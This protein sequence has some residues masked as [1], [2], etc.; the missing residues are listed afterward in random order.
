MVGCVS[1]C[2]LS[3]LQKPRRCRSA[4]QA[5]E[6][7]PGTTSWGQEHQLLAAIPDDAMSILD[8]LPSQYLCGSEDEVRLA[9]QIVS[10]LV[11]EGHQS[12]NF[13]RTG[14]GDRIQIQVGR[15]REI[16]CG[17]RMLSA[18]DARTESRRNQ[19]RR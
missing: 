17:G 5:C 11:S 12:V 15:Q 4:C 14:S 16:L 13:V 7:G 8:I 18:I 9:V 3:S 1:L 6:N 2:G 10:D 19:A